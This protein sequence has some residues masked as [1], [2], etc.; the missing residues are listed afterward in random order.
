MN[1][2][3]RP[4]NIQEKRQALMWLLFAFAGSFLLWH[5]SLQPLWQENML[6]LQQQENLKR[7]I[8]LYQEF[9]VRH[10]DYEAYAASQTA[11]LA[12][13]ERQLPVQADAGRLLGQWQRQAALDGVQ[14]TQMQALAV[15]HKQNNV[16]SRP[17]KLT[18]SGN[19]YAVLKFIQ[20]LEKS[21]NFV[22]L[23]QVSIRGDENK[24]NVKLTGVL[25]IYQRQ[26]AE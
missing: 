25:N 12:N 6:K 15:E 16:S 4:I 24:G 23:T 22:N 19:Y 21:E 9:A 18:L 17:V 13:L 3:S 1:N 7:E 2:M 14:I 10:S 8:R 5:F 11:Q 26:A 20:Y